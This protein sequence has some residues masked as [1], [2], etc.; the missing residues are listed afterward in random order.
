MT[1]LPKLLPPQYFPSK[2]DIKRNFIYLVRA[3]NTIPLKS[4]LSWRLINS[5]SL[6]KI[7]SLQIIMR[8][9]INE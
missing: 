2:K 4:Q 6:K 1:V 8:L 7:S 3:K 9:W 5:Q